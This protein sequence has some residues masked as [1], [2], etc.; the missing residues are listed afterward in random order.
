MCGMRPAQLLTLIEN[1]G[2]HAP[3]KANL[4]TEHVTRDA[5]ALNVPRQA[6][7]GEGLLTEENFENMNLA[8]TRLIR[9]G[10]A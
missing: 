3:L 7:L 6:S 2:T 1:H 8:P 10:L 5:N 9:M 4:L